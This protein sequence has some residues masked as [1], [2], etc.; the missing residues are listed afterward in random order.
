VQKSHDDTFFK[1]TG[2]LILDAI[3]KGSKYNHDD[4][5]DNLLPTL[6][7][8]RTENA[9]LKVSPTL[10]MYVDNSKSHKRAKN[11]EKMSLKGLGRADHPTYSRDISSGDFWAFETI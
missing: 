8:V 11:T 7:Q 3:L 9:G 1:A 5:I 4:F 2:R 10:M 6:N